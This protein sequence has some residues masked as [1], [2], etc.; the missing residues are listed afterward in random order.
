MFKGWLDRID[1]E[2]PFVEWPNFDSLVEVVEH[3]HFVELFERNFNTYVFNAMA[4]T[5]AKR[6]GGS[7]YFY[8]GFTDQQ[9]AAETEAFY[10]LTKHLLETYDGT[11]MEIVFQNWEGDWIAVA[12]AGNEGPP[13]SDVLERMKRWFNARQRGIS[14]ARREVESDVAVLGACEVNRVREP[15]ETDENWIVNTILSELDVDLVSYSAWDL[16]RHVISEPRMTDALREDV[17]ETLDYIAEH[18]P[19]KSA[20]ATRALGSDTPQVYLG[21]YGMALNRNG[22]DEAMRAIRTVDE[23]ARDW[24]VPYTLF[25]ATYDNGVV[26][27]GEQVTVDPNIESILQEEFPEGVTRDDVRGYYL[28]YPDGTRTPPW[29]RLAEAFDTNQAEFHRLDLEFDRTISSAELDPDIERGEGRELAFTCFEIGIETTQGSTTLNVGT[30]R[31]EGALAR[32]VFPPEETNDATFRWF[33]RPAAHTRLY[34]HRG[35]L[36]LQGPIEQLRLKGSGADDDLGVRVLLDGQSVEALTL[37]TTRRE[38]R[39]QVD[40]TK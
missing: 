23:E 24:G 26:I 11:G 40:G 17:H 27:D 35:E 29:Y 10:E 12:G 22:I 34:L 3:P 39:V 20:Y 37:D 38:Y 31:E 18:A 14:R 2:Y 1:A 7:G 28:R 13:D 19:P 5:N 32:G 33:G 4:L 21:E 30:P 6:Q 9:A 25:W 8:H 16:C 15:I 36:G